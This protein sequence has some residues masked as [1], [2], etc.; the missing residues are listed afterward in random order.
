LAYTV[1]KVIGCYGPLIPAK[2]VT[3]TALVEDYSDEE[4]NKVQ[5]VDEEC[6]D[7]MVY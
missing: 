2:L 3:V 6:E 4:R 1:G 5:Q 7:R